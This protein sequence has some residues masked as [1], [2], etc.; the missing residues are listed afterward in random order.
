MHKVLEGDYLQIHCSVNETDDVDVYWVKNDTTT[1][2]IQNGTTLAL[3]NITRK[4]SGDYIC[5]SQNLASDN[6]A[7]EVEVIKVDVLCEY[8]N[9]STYKHCSYSGSTF[10]FVIHK[11]KNC[12]WNKVTVV[13]KNN[14]DITFRSLEQEIM[15]VCFF[16]MRILSATAARA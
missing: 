14:F 4:M 2:F 12:F 13:C 9:K 16:L 10:L 6:N 7:T 11:T 8:I 15:V 1:G 3:V 5:Y